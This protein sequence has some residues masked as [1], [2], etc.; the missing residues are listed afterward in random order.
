M[1]TSIDNPPY[2]KLL[3]FWLCRE[4]FLRAQAFVELAPP[5]DLKEAQRE[6][7][8]FET[9]YLKICKAIEDEYPDAYAKLIFSIDR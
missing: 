1:T 6:V 3:E 9:A 8:A 5:E 2:E 7:L 4:N